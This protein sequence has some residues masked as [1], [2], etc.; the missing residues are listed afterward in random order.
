[1]PAPQD[2]FEL[3]KADL[4]KA[5]ITVVPKAMKWAPDY[6]DATEAAFLRPAHAGLDR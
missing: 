2:M 3:M 6:L 4:E 1:M 5:G